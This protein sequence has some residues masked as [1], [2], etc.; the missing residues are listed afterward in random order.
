MMADP[1][2]SDPM[3]PC[4]YQGVMNDFMLQWFDDSAPSREARLL[5]ADRRFSIEIGQRQRP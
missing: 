5:P 4:M 2:Y 3:F 1:K